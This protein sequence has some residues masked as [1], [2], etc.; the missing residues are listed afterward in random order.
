MLCALLITCTSQQVSNESMETVEGI[1][2]SSSLQE[3]PKGGSITLLWA[4]ITTLDPH[5][6]QDSRSAQIA[7][8]IF[9]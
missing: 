4:D 8:E 1:A 5:L 9:N 7:L 2:E 6:V 3:N